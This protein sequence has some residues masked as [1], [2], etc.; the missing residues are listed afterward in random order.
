MEARLQVQLR[1]GYHVNSHTPSED[2]LIPLR[3]NWEAAP[4]EAAETAYP[5]PRLEKYEFSEKPIS[6]FSGEFEIVSRFRVPATAP[7]GPNLIV[8]KLRYQAC[9]E[10]MCL[11]PKTLEVRL[12]V[13]IQ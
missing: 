4:L 5:K 13:S 7:Q 9:T 3:L 11:P 8:G 1:P 2:Y 12:P 6:V 10:R